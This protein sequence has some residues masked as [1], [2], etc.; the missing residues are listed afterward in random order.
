VKA[1]QVAS[2][3]MASGKGHKWPLPHLWPLPLSCGT[4]VLCRATAEQALRIDSNGDWEVDF[5]LQLKTSE[6]GSAPV[7]GYAVDSVILLLC[8]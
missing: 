4:K 7:I 2:T 8:N 5:S 3:K 1:L 6:G